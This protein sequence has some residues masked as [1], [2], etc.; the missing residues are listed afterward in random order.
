LGEILKKLKTTG[1]D[2]ESILLLLLLLLTMI[3]MMNFVV[4]GGWKICAVAL[5]AVFDS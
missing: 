2:K 5:L 1:I 4:W 3:H